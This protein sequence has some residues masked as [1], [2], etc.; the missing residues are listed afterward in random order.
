[1][2]LLA[3]VPRDLQSGGEGLL[4]CFIFFVAFH[5]EQTVDYVAVRPCKNVWKQ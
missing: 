1:M 3:Q 5:R 2:L 4:T